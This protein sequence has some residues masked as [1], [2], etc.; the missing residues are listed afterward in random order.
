M[1]MRGRRQLR[2]TSPIS[3]LRPAN[4]SQARTITMVRP[5]KAEPNSPSRRKSLPPQSNLLRRGTISATQ[6]RIRF[7]KPCTNNGEQTA[8]QITQFD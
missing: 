7:T 3:E 8:G 1:A 5:K 2:T 4:E 6:L